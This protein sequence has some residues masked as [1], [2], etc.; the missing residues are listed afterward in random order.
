MCFGPVV[1]D[2]PLCG[3]REVGARPA[4]GNPASK[5]RC[6]G[7]LSY[8]GPAVGPRRG[9]GGALPGCCSVGGAW[10]LQDVAWGCGR[11]RHDG[12]RL[13]QTPSCL[14]DPPPQFP[15]FP[16]FPHFSGRV[17]FGKKTGEERTRR[18]GRS[19]VVNRGEHMKTFHN[20]TKRKGNG[21]EMGGKWAIFRHLFHCT[22]FG[23]IFAA[24]QQLSFQCPH[25]NLWSPECPA[26]RMGEISPERRG[27]PEVQRVRRIA[28]ERG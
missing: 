16:M 25:K 5:V 20:E 22:P 19:A 9:G 23:P 18:L 12:S 11:K 8:Q 14:C 24:A 17:A 28:T 13:L 3:F 7:C 10:Q 1:S 26:G 4:P 6:S 15:P 2:A 27:A 21:R